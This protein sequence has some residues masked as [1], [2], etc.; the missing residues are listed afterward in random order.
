MK[1]YAPAYYK[2][3]KCIADKCTH[4]C[5]VGWEISVD[6]Q[7]EARYNCL[8]VSEREEILSHIEDGVIRLCPD[9][10]CPFLDGQGLCRII[11]GHGEGYVSEICREHPRFYNFCGDRAEVGLGL[12]CEEAA[13]I[14][15]SSNNFGVIEKIGENDSDVYCVEYSALAERDRLFEILNDKST[16]YREKVLKIEK[17]YEIS[18]SEIDKN[19]IQEIYSELEYLDNSHKNMILSADFKASASL[20]DELT[21]FLAYMVYRHVSVATDFDNLR[22]RV[23]F[24]LLS[25]RVLEAIAIS[26]DNPQ[27]DIVECARIYSEEIEYSEDNTSALIFEFEAQL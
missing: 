13:R 9:G 2:D 17:E 11:S 10:K 20:N 23:S 7:T 6:E 4:S 25:A 3:F 22:A 19:E 5:C 18:V 15:L 1:L 14:V 21:A 8:S 24:C 12:S 26:S 16:G 27:T